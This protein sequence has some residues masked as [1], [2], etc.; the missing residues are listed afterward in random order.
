MSYGQ[1]THCG[2]VIPYGN[3]DL[4]QHWLRKWL[5][6]IRQH[7]IIWAN[8]DLAPLWFCDIQLRSISQVVFQDIYS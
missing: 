4:G 2:L 6:A 8:V 7:A 1:L 5:V 3:I